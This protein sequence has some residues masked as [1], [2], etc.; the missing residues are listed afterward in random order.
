MSVEPV[1][2][3][4]SYMSRTS[5]I[6][7]YEPLYS[8]PRMTYIFRGVMLVF[9][10][11]QLYLGLT[12]DR[13]IDNLYYVSFVGHMMVILYYTVAF[14][15]SFRTH[16]EQDLLTFVLTVIFQL[17]ASMQFLIFVFYWGVMAYD[18]FYKILEKDNASPLKL[19]RLAVALVQ[20]L[21][22]P[23]VIW[24]TIL[25]ERTAFKKSNAIFCYIFTLAY[26]VMN[27]YKT[28]TSGVPVYDII[29]W[30]SLSSHIHLAAAGG[31][32]LIGFYLSAKLS[33]RM[34]VVLGFHEKDKND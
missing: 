23:V 22:F 10:I 3:I 4:T 28:A 5:A 12:F 7:P 2:G 25:M 14:I 31:L 24:F 34:S 1:I 20:H 13:K 19:R 8:S 32:V 15:H 9:S 26:C 29:D 30:Q 16:T 17:T 11:W 6:G 27:G 21:M 33:K 18:D